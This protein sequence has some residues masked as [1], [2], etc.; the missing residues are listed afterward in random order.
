MFTGIIKKTAEIKNLM[1]KNQSFFVEINRPFDW[2]LK[3]GDSVSVNGICS[4][5]NKIS[6]NSFFVEY[7]P[8]TIDKTTVL[9]WKKQE[10]VNLEKSLSMKD[11]MDGHMVLGHIDQKGKIMRIDKKGDSKVFTIQVPKN[12]MKYIALKGSV[13]VDG[14]SLT[15]VDA[16]KDNFTVSLV[17]Y[18]FSNTNLENKKTGDSIN[19]ETDIIAKYIFN[20]LN[21]SAYAKRRK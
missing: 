19:I 18:T 17:N 12:L 15:V 10:I 13:A 11:L 7:M 16:F 8:E 5:V 2:K 9:D 4:T 14:I 6:K 3:L 1:K 21:N 20:I